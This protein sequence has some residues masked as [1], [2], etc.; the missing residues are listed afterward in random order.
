MTSGPFR[1]SYEEA[2]TIKCDECGAEP[3]APCVYLWPTGVPTDKYIDDFSPGMRVKILRAGKPT[4]RPHNSRFAGAWEMAKKALAAE[5]ARRIKD[6]IASLSKA[7]AKQ[8]E[9]AYAQREWDRQEWLRLRDWL[10][11]WGHMFAQ[12]RRDGKE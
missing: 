6:H 1:T 11:R 10:R 9:I 5:K 4:L 3:G 8:R 7:T 2:L 12:P